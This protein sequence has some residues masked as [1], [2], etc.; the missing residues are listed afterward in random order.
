LAAPAIAYFDLAVAGR[1]AV[2]DDEMISETV[3]HPPD[4]PMIVVER[5]G[6]A[7][8]CPAVVHDNVL[9]TT[10]HD[11][12]TIDLRADGIRE[13]S[14]IAAAATPAAAAEKPGK[15]TDRLLVTRFLDIDLRR[16]FFDGRDGRRRRRHHDGARRRRRRPLNR[17]GY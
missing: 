3:L 17:R 5:C 14:I 16:F 6:I 4:M 7:L 1:G 8:P 11:R 12:R 2:A 9:P 13:I 10:R 15:E